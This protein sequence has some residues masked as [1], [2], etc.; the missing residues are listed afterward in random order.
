MIA[1]LGIIV[2]ILAVGVLAQTMLILSF[3]R[4]LHKQNSVVES[5]QLAS[6]EQATELKKTNIA[7]NKER[8]EYAQQRKTALAL[9]EKQGFQKAF[10]EELEKV[11]KDFDK[12]LDGAL[13]E[14]EDKV[15]FSVV[16]YKK[17]I[18]KKRKIATRKAEKVRPPR[19]S[20]WRSIYD[21]D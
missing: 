12:K 3:R 8:D 10:N 6:A 4:A 5:L 11:K 2:V 13:K 15:D 17:T 14:A 9:I 20:L 7:L 1:I 16:Q 19:Q 18:T 21:E